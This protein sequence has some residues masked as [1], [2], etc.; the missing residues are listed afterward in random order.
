MWFEDYGN[1]NLSSRI[2]SNPVV[3]SLFVDCQVCEVSCSLR[4]GQL[5]WILCVLAGDTSRTFVGG[6][7]PTP[8]LAIPKPLFFPSFENTPRMEV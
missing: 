1:F 2:N 5:C 4:I 6:H 8:G 3:C 7:G